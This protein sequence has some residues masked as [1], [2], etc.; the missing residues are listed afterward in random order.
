MLARSLLLSLCAAVTGC[1][2]ALHAPRAPDHEIRERWLPSFVF[3]IFGEPA[4]E[5]RDVCP[6]GVATAVSV[7]TNA[8]TV[9]VSILTLG[10]YTP[11]KV[12]VACARRH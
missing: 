7:G 10:I 8:G 12:W 11:R 4:L 9:G 2:P 1:A 5:V 6:S 3:G